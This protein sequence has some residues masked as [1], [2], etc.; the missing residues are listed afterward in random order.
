MNTF[1]V[2]S[3][4]SGL[5]LIELLLTIAIIGIIASLAV[6]FFSS[7][8]ENAKTATAKG[9][10]HV[11]SSMSI[12]LSNVG[13]HFQSSNVPDVVSEIRKGV[14]IETG[15]FKGKTFSVSLLPPQGSEDEARIFRFLTFDIGNGVL[16]YY[17]DGKPNKLTAPAGVKVTKR[18]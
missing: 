8:N 3:F 14:T 12:D 2:R 13:H 5:S 4:R 10:A 16:V 18:L 15:S 6:G 7:V 11:L 17:P 9:H 1:K